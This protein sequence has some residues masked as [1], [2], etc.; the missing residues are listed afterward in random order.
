MCTRY[1]VQKNI[2]TFQFIRFECP[3]HLVR[4]NISFRNKLPDDRKD[5]CN[6][7]YMRNAMLLTKEYRFLFMFKK[8]I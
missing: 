8:N 7:L 1:Y 4:I 3:L 5:T 2:C 6:G